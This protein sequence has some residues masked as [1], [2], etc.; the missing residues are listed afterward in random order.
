MAAKRKGGRGGGMKGAMKGG[1]TGYI[2]SFLILLVAAGI[3][4]AYAK[5]NNINS[6]A[7][8]AD[9]TKTTSDK[10]QVCLEPDVD[11]WSCGNPFSSDSPGPTR[12][13][14]PKDGPK[15]YSKDDSKD[16]PKDNPTEDGAKAPGNDSAAKSSAT[17]DKLKAIPVGDSKKVDY[18]R[19]TWNHWVGD[20]CNDTR[21]Q[22]LKEQAV[23]Y[24]LDSNNCKVA[25]GEW[26]D[27]YTGET[28]TDPGKLD[29]DHVY[30]LGAAARNGGNDW[31]ADR[32]EQFAND[33]SHLLAVSASA[34]RSKSDENPSE[35][36]PENNAY[37]CDFATIYVDVAAKYNLQF[38][39]K[40][41]SALE[42][43]LKT[44]N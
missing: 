35:W 23:S 5:A 4:F 31:D 11:F 39:S 15:D 34:N 14:T 7:S 37:S 13:D 21:Q 43:G 33:K 20:R 27:P 30:S 22:V 19:S 36:W 38:S 6:V 26:I 3:V 25:S 44:C 41:V 28:F 40:D 9:W 16:A 1:P 8:F 42:K 10:F 12:H 32:K 18:D 29:I 2:T 17:L 24:K